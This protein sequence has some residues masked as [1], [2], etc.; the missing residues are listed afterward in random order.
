MYLAKCEE[1]GDEDG[2]RLLLMNWWKTSIKG[3]RPKISSGYHRY[4]AAPGATI[5]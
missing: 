4:T 2:K 3:R 1:F 5:K